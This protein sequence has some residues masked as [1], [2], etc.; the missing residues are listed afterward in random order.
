MGV[1][2]RSKEIYG[3][4]I[5]DESM[6]QVMEMDEADQAYFWTKLYYELDRRLKRSWLKDMEHVAA[7]KVKTQVEPSPTPFKDAEGSIGASSWF[8]RPHVL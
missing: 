4:F 3:P 6:R 8:G 7:S 2:E 1:I 5:N